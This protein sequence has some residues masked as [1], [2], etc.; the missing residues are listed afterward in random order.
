[1]VRIKN[2][3]KEE[4]DLHLPEKEVKVIDEADEKGKLACLD[5]NRN[6]LAMASFPLHSQQKRQ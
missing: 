6:E 1:M 5:V 2:I 4:S 3:L